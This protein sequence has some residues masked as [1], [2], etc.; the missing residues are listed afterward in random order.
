M[1][2]LNSRL[3]LP[4]DWGPEN[5]NLVAIATDVAC[6]CRTQ[7]VHGVMPGPHLF[8]FY[9][10]MERHA[11]PKVRDLQECAKKIA[12]ILAGGHSQRVTK[13]PGHVSMAGKTTV[14]GNFD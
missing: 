1:Q 7:A 9:R 14:G 3:V 11:C 10:E 6:S 8:L 5:V 2:D 4:L 12:P 13:S